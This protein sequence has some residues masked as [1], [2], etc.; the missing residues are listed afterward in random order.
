[1]Q[2]GS[3]DES[4]RQQDLLGYYSYILAFPLNFQ[5]SYEEKNISVNLSSSLK[6]F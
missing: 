3:A 2:Q 6:Q 5:L 4:K 1:V